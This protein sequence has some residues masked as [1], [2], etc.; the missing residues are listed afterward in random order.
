MQ[1]YAYIVELAS[2]LSLS[3]SMLNIIVKNH[4]KIDR[5]YVHCEPY[6]KQWKS[7]KIVDYD[8]NNADETGLFSVYNLAK[9]SVFEEIFAMVV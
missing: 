7:G 2:C 8:I 4:E 3:V 6:S 5:R 9:P 1:V